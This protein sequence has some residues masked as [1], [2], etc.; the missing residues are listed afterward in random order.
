MT[1][2]GN[3]ES[4][5]HLLEQLEQLHFL[6]PFTRIIQQIGIHLQD[7]PSTKARSPLDAAFHNLDVLERRLKISGWGL[8]EREIEKRAD[9]CIEQAYR[10]AKNEPKIAK[11]FLSEAD[12][13]IDRLDDKSR[14]CAVDRAYEFVMQKENRKAY[15]TII[16]EIDHAK[17]MIQENWGKKKSFLSH[18]DDA[19]RES[20]KY[21]WNIGFLTYPVMLE[22]MHNCFNK[23]EQ[24][25]AYAAPQREAFMREG[26]A[27]AKRI[28]YDIEQKVS[29]LPLAIAEQY[30]NEAGLSKRRYS[31]F[32]GVKDPA[33]E[34]NELFSVSIRSL[35]AA[36][37]LIEGFGIPIKRPLRTKLELRVAEL[38]M[39]SHA[40]KG[41]DP[42]LAK[43]ANDYTNATATFYRSR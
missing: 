34:L 11:L 6:T 31:G 1:Q 3:N 27:I 21:Q 12:Q 33:K 24:Q 19:Q 37:A 20:R 7:P 30:L 26:L 36:Q 4:L 10:Y 40:L 22:R 16:T 41:I 18:L 14:K 17:S 23:S 35:D 2:N 15:R 38:K 8:L 42:K 28:D 25:Q 32:M 39:F 43:A 29:Y 13:R 5:E 9:Y